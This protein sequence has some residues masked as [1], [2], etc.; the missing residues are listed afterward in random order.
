MQ[1]KIETVGLRKVS[2][3]GADSSKVNVIDISPRTLKPKNKQS[4]FEKA[5]KESSK[6]DRHFFPPKDPAIHIEI[7]Q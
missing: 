2:K 6:I 7:K 3:H 1:Q 5:I 4:E